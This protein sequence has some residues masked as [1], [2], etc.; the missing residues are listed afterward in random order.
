MAPF[1]GWR[2][3]IKATEP[4]RG[5]NFLFTTNSSEVTDTHLIYHRKLKGQYI[6]S[7]FYKP[8]RALSLSRNF[9]QFFLEAIY[10]TMVWENLENYSVQIA[11]KCNCD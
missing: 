2:S 4:L 10:V 8:F 11:I 6:L 3:N 5:D 9:T 7:C 1:Y